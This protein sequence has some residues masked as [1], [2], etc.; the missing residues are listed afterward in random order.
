[1]WC[2]FVIKPTI[3]M[4]AR[5]ISLSTNLLNLIFL[6]FP[7]LY[8][9]TA[10]GFHLDY[11]Y[12]YQR[13]TDP[14]YF[15]LL[16][17]INVAL[18]NL[19]TPY[20]DHPGT[21]LQVIV[22]ISAWPIS[23]F[24]PGTLVENVTDHP[25]VF[26]TG[27]LI[28]MN[29]IIATTLFICGKKVYNYTG[30]FWI[31]FFIQ[32]I[33]FT[34][35]NYLSA[36][37]R[38]IPET[39]MIVPV[40][41]LCVYLI[42]I[43]YS[44]VKNDL[45][46]R[47]IIILALIA[48]L[49]MAS[50]FSY[51]PLILVPVFIIG[52]FKKVLKYGLLSAFFTLVFAFPIVFNLKQAYTWFGNMLINDGKWGTGS[53]SFI[54]WD[55]AFIN[56]EKL[57]SINHFF[58]VLLIVVLILS[59]YTTFVKNERTS[60]LRRVSWGL[61]LGISVLIFFITKHFA[62]HYYYPALLFQSILVLLILFFVYRL[63]VLNTGFS[64]V[65]PIIFLG[66]LGYS[67][68]GV[69]DFFDRYKNDSANRR[70][71]S[72]WAKEVTS[73]KT[74][75]IPIIISSSFKGCPFPEYSFSAAYLLCGHLKTTFTE[76]FINDYPDSYFYVGWS[77]KFFSWNRFLLSNEFLDPNAGLYVYIGENRQ[78]NYNIILDRI[79]QSFPEYNINSEV[80]AE[81]TKPHETFYRISFEEKQ[82]SN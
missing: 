77:E 38:L 79:R 34:N 52:S 72:K 21:P 43:L 82:V 19:A 71:Y 49:G 58:I 17:G 29:L 61:L 15:H 48:G 76:K 66:F 37:A 41:F 68:S 47:D 44:S 73:K 18:F 2:I 10:L 53:S 45:T 56:L 35:V 63:K 74:M 46:N 55:S 51:F 9:S 40:V 5:K 8:V 1:M 7:V 80:I 30:S 6:L 65:L 39:F 57:I 33:P 27:A 50:K 20:I 81:L 13:I 64:K 54:N 60:M 12:Y 11:G 59:L 70:D 32:I 23:L 78:V 36:G 26:I 62:F 42:K 3:T 31:A 4:N 67:I 28:L 75:D 16:N 14:E 22:A 24:Y 69:P 25:E